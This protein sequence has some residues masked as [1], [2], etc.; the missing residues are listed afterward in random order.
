MKALQRLALAIALGVSLLTCHGAAQTRFATLYSF[1]NGIPTGLSPGNG[2]LY[3]AFNG[4]TPTGS[5]CGY[6]F[7]LQPPSAAGGSWTETVVYSFAQTNDGCYPG[8]GPVVGAGG[9]LYGLTSLGG[10]Y[11]YGIVYELQPPSSPGGAW[12][13]SVLYSFGT[14]T[15]G[16]STGLVP[17]PG[18]SFYV[19]TANALFQLQPPPSPGGAW[20]GTSLYRL[21]G[22]VA[23]SVSLTAGPDGVLYGTVA[24]GGTAPGGLGEVFQLTPHGG[25]RGNLDGDSAPQLRL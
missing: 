19:M 7:E 6:I 20:T 18:G 15:G 14:D 17:G 12:T 21:S 10:A 9:T 16:P 11:G 13:E 25:A 2:V 3:G 5:S 23:G 1:T 8:L 22:G 24:Q 4:P